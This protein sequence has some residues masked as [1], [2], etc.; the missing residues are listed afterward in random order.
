MLRAAISRLAQRPALAMGLLFAAGVAFTALPSLRYGPP[1][2]ALHDEYA[3]LFLGETLARGRLTNPPPPGPP[4]FYQTFHEFISPRYVSKFPP[5]PGIALALGIWLG[6]PILGVWLVNGLWAVALYWMLRA[7]VSPGWALG[8]ALAGVISYGAMSYWGYSYWGGSV[9]ALGG[10]LAFGG[11]LRCWKKRGNSLG[12]AVW[13]GV[14]CGI[15]ALTRPLDGLIFALGPAGMMLWTAW[16]DLRIGGGVKIA[17]SRILGFGLPAAAGVALMLGYNVATT[18]S[19]LT[20]AHRL[21]DETFLPRVV[22][23]V[24]EKP[25]HDPANQPAFLANYE[26]VYATNM[27]ADPLTATQYWANL[28]KFA[29]AQFHFLFPNWV[30]PLAIFAVG[31]IFFARDRTARLALL[32]LLCIALPLCTLRYYDFS[33]YVAAWTAPALLLTIQGA[34]RLRA[35]GHSIGPGLPCLGCV[36]CAL[37]VAWPTIATVRELTRGYPQWLQF[38]WVYDREQTRQELADLAQQT[39]HKQL[40]LVIYAPGHDPHA[41]WVYNSPEPSAQ[42]VLWLRALGQSRVPELLN[43][44]PGYDDWLVYVTAEGKIDHREKIQ[45]VVG[46]APAP[47]SSAK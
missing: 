20:F 9:F 17:R 44:F 3:D 37:L 25:G 16:R 10:T 45:F 35:W 27:S 32:S 34:R 15:M 26:D 2:P 6:N 29:A 38:K 5:G 31:A 39:G 43:E 18:G 1:L 24:W 41:E 23:F 21:Y 42:D 8:G 46:A 22:L 19:A 33:H 30:W 28:Q 7:V 36:A 11:A 40:A 4:E 12:A 47:A 14:G 13:A